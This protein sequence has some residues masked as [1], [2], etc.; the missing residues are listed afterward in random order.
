MLSIDNSIDKKR[1]TLGD[2]EK[3]VTQFVYIKM[4]ACFAIVVLHCVNS[5]AIYH[6]EE[7]SEGEA[8][9]AQTV[10]SMLMW[11][12]PCFLMVTGAL[13]LDPEKKITLQK[14]FGKY[15]RR[16]V[17]A[18]IVFTLIFTFIRHDA[19]NGTGLMH[20]FFDGL[21]FNH[22]MAYLWYLY[23]MIALYLTM[24]VWKAV[25]ERFNDRQILIMLLIALA[26]VSLLPLAGYLDVAA[27]SYIPTW[28]VY[29]CYLFIGY[30][31]KRHQ[32]DPRLAAAVFAVCTA[33]LGL[34]T[35]M[36]A[37][38]DLDPSGLSGYNSPI[39]VLQS[40][41]V[42]AMMLGIRREASSLSV[43]IDRCSFGIYLIHMLF[44]RLI[45]KELGFDPFVYGPFGFITF[46]V[47]VFA[48]SYGMTWCLK[49]LPGFGWL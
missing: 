41:A 27:A 42:Y 33:S 4:A 48:A 12:V 2:S 35:Y 30:L 25:T 46:A 47:I 18:L 39:V 14:L 36:A 15:I 31:I 5:A 40:A 44:F 45:M 38:T 37:P 29:P 28:L 3:R 8:L 7:I 32:P 19:S 34:I 43:S 23:L 17:T 13:L 10:V 1:S 11:A 6:A 16:M 9:A 20:E 26:A 21:L 24:P 49:K 22:C